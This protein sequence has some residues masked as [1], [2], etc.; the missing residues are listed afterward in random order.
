MS[1]PDAKISRWNTGYAGLVLGFG[2]L[3]TE[4][5]VRFLNHIPLLLKTVKRSPR[6]KLEDLLVCLMAGVES[7]G[8][9]NSSLRYDRGLAL[10]VGRESL[11]DQSLLSQTLDAFDAKTVAKLRSNMVEVIAERS[12]A[13]AH[14]PA[15]RHHPGPGHDGPA[16]LGAMR[17]SHQGTNHSP[18][19]LYGQT[20]ERGLQSPFP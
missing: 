20:T 17:G 14:R 9:I 7:L 3:K 10:A 13:G 1:N 15:P 8:Q 5:L 18:T 4:R 12:R 19:R 2:W 6:A 16:L 11:A